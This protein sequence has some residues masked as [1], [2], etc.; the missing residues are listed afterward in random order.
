MPLYVKPF[1][2]IV[3]DAILEMREKS[4]DSTV[5]KKYQ[6]RVNDVYMFDIPLNFEFDPLS[7]HLVELRFF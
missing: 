7:D 2:A 4:T 5:E 1:T 3:E 6:R